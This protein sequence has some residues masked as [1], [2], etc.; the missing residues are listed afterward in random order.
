MR[1]LPV[2][3]RSPSAEPSA[4]AARARSTRLDD[5]LAS[6]KRRIVSL[7]RIA[8]FPLRLASGVHLVRASGV[9]DAGLVVARLRAKGAL[10]LAELP[11]LLALDAPPVAVDAALLAAT[12]RDLRILEQKEAR[13]LVAEHRKVF[14]GRRIDDAWL[15]AR[16]AELARIAEPIAEAAWFDGVVE[17]VHAVRGETEATHAA[18]AGQ[19]IMARG[20]ERRREARDRLDAV[21]VALEAG[22]DDEH[23][24][25]LDAAREL[26]GRARRRRVLDVLRAVVGWPDAPRELVRGLGTPSPPEDYAARIG[27]AGERMAASLPVLRDPA[28]RERALEMLATLVLVFRLGDDPVPVLDPAET[29]L[30]D[31][32]TLRSTGLTLGMACEVLRLLPKQQRH[33]VGAWIAEGLSL[34]LVRDAVTHGLV[35]E[36]A[37]VSDVRAA[38][39]YATWATRLRAHY[40]EQGI[41]FKLS[42][43]LFSNLP[44]RGEDLAVLAMC[45][46]EQAD[47]KAT[48]ADPVATLDATLALFQRL[49]N[50]AASVLLRLRGGTPGAARRIVPDLAAWLDDDE[51]LDRCIH[52][53]TVCGQPHLSAAIREDFEHG[54][55]VRRER[56]YLE[57]QATLS[58]PQRGRLA[59]LTAS[60]PLASAP[61]G[62]TKRRI[63]ERIQYLLPRAYRHELDVAFREIL[64]EVWGIRVPTLTAAW[65]DAVRFWLVTDDNR[66]HLGR[67]LRDAAAGRDPKRGSKESEAWIAK[68]TFDVDA[69]LAPRAVDVMVDGKRWTATVETDALEVLRMGI[70]FATCLSLEDGC[71]AASTVLNALDPNKRVVYVRN[72]AGRVVARKLLA[73]VPGHRLAGYN[74]YVSVTGPAETA[75]RDAVRDLVR[76][77]ATDAG[78]ALVPA[79]EPET[80]HTGFW[81]DDGTV[82]FEDDAEV[83]AYCHHL[84][85]APPARADDDLRREAH[86]WWASTAG[87]VDDAI[88]TLSFY[89]AGPANAALGDWVV[90]RLGPRAAATHKETAVG[91]ALGRSLAVDV[92]G[93]LRAIELVGRHADMRWTDNRLDDLLA[94]FPASPRIARALVDLLPKARR[95]RTGDR[96]DLAHQLSR[97]LP[98]QL[99]SVA[100]SFDVL[101]ELSPLLD[102]MR[103][104][105]CATCAFDAVSRACDAVEGLHADAP[106]PDAVLAAL[107]APRRSTLARTVALRIAA[108]HV[109]PGGIRVLE[110]MRAPELLA[111]PD[112]L[113]AFLRQAEVAIIDEAIAARV[114]QPADAP[115]A[116]LRELLFLPGI[117]RVLGRHRGT[118]DIASWRPD[119]WELAWRRRHTDPALE[120]ALV[121]E[122]AQKGPSPARDRLALLAAVARLD[123]LAPKPGQPKEHVLFATLEGAKT[124]AHS[125]RAQV[126]ARAFDVTPRGN[127]VDALYAWRAAAVSSKPGAVD[128]LVASPLREL[129][130]PE[131]IVLGADDAVAIAM[132]EAHK[133]LLLS[134]AGA[135]ALWQRPAVRDALVQRIHARSQWLAFAR[136]IFLEAEARG[137]NVDGL[138]EATA[139][140][141]VATPD[142]R[143]SRLHGAT[144][145]L[146]A[147]VFAIVVH[148]AEPVNVVRLYA[149]LEDAL[150]VSVFLRLLAREPRARREEVRTEARKLEQSAHGRKLFV[151][152]LL[153]HGGSLRSRSASSIERA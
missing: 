89:G 31:L 152:W 73:V 128:V 38:R 145:E 34:D 107:A 6:L 125:L 142:A 113:A 120:E 98:A 17:V 133:N 114:P 4:K 109:L 50:K 132:L 36:L 117:E 51:L 122:A 13:A 72:D 25:R 59:S 75:V 10:D 77:L 58:V 18:E 94:S 57:A 147:R 64:R 76:A 131:R 110:R 46:L 95:V 111:T 74:L 126:A 16:R 45:L 37:E 66:E 71:N 44:A 60:P 149:Q 134:P 123:E 153:A 112:G 47:P 127:T 138:L 53:E 121:A 49:P 22:T 90:S 119:P 2:S 82:P 5:E 26:P 136:A 78:L 86:G 103:A 146:L 96:D 118:P 139:L 108:R 35:E 55:R 43:E 19:R 63:G 81:Y 62:R 88:A 143:A 8:G 56:A 102:E 106:D 116:A 11:E 80:V 33:R 61:R 41:V 28:V 141:W 130:A 48:H 137:A 29:S 150:S 20:A 84:G 148:A 68:Q 30:K 40:K 79:G 105:S 14:G 70:P 21:L 135:V 104:D 9:R 115:F 52:L 99:D 151:P 65:R 91:H 101:D 97:M 32:V 100:G 39:A 85:L 23:A 69:W 93:L 92:E 7:E 24:A 42:P 140:A 144:S 83:G 129:V 67:L 87:R 54:A 1:R 27:A 124:A 15:A 12:R 3:R